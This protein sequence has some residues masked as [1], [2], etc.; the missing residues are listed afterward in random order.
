MAKVSFTRE[1][2]W[3]KVDGG[4]GVIGITNYA[5][6]QL[7]DIVFVDLPAVGQQ[8]KQG[9]EAAV[10]ESVKAASELYAPAS[11]E[12]VA[13]NEALVDDPARVNEDAMNRG[14]FFKI[15][16]SDPNELSALL[17]EAAYKEYVESLG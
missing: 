8:V 12:V 15:S 13:V 14:W 9:E 10:V 4:E 2:E 7:G 16:L 3:I 1:H 11:G 5:Q 6:E 17:D